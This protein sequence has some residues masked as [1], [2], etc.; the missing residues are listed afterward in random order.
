[1]SVPPIKI[2]PESGLSSRV[3]HRAIVDFP[4]PD[5]PTSANVCPHGIS[6]SAQVN[7]ATGTRPRHRPP[8]MYRLLSPCT[9]SHGGGGGAAFGAA[10]DEL[11]GESVGKLLPI[12]ETVHGPRRLRY[13]F[14][15]IPARTNVHPLGA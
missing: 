2:E 15:R 6:K 3:T 11:P 5:S 14:G 9:R 12:F 8:R 10:F 7:A 4:D 1:M 13:K